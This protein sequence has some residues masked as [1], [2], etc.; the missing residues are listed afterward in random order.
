MID[1]A[2]LK[3]GL[4]KLSGTYADGLDVSLR[5]DRE[6]QK[7]TTSAQLLLQKK[8]LA[9]G[10]M[11]NWSGIIKTLSD[12]LTPIHKQLM[13]HPDDA[14]GDAFPG[15]ETEKILALDVARAS[16]QLNSELDDNKYLKVATI[17]AGV[18]L[19]IGILAHASKS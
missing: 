10:A 19:G 6:F 17:G 12:R 9:A 16:N 5:L 18:L 14:S 1:E 15:W 7:M 11:D 2:Q 4:N 3:V 8:N 13:A